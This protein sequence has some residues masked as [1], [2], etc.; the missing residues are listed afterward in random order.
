MGLAASAIT[1]SLLR[2]LPRHERPHRLDIVGAVLIVV[3]SVS[4]MLALNIGGVRYP[5][6]LAAD[7]GAAC[8]RAGRGRFFVVRL[9]TA[10]EP[11]IPVSILTHPI[12]R[13]AIAANA[14]GWGAIIGLNIIL[15]IYLQSVMGLSPTSAGLS[16]MVF[17]VAMNTS[18]GLAGQVLGRVRHYKLLPMIGSW[19][20]SGRSRPWR[21]APTA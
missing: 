10:P 17:M 12:V 20:R 9:L 15:P 5:V 11:L 3:A 8:G 2:R 16:L 4:F 13:Y 1:P 21:G 18:A 7:P 14:F 19:S 6:D